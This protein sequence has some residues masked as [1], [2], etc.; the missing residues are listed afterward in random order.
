MLNFTL[1][2]ISTCTV[3]FYGAVNMICRACMCCFALSEGG[4]SPVQCVLPEQDS[5]G[6]AQEPGGRPE[7]LLSGESLPPP[8]GQ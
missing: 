1:S 8:R 2:K 6:D 5:L 7:P 3:F 4:V